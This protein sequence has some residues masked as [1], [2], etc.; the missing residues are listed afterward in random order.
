MA[1]RRRFVCGE[2]GNSVDAWSDGNP[3]YIDS[4]GKKQ[5][6]YHPNHRELDKCIGND[7]EMY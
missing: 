1:E 7:G 5:Y 4:H 2:C 3:Y 6:A